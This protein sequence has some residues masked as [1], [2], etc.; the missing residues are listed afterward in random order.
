VEHQQAHETT[1]AVSFFEGCA[2]QQ[3]L[4]PLAVD[5][6]TVQLESGRFDALRGKS[7]LFGGI[8]AS[9][10]AIGTPVYQ[11]R[12]AGVHAFR[13]D[14]SDIPEG[15]PQL[16]D[17]YIAVSQ[18]GRSR[19][20]VQ[21]LLSVPDAYSL[22]ITN[23]ASNPLLSVSSAGLSVGNFPD[24]RVSSIGFTATLL[25]L[26][27]LADRIAGGPVDSRWSAVIAGLPD[28]LAQAEDTLRLFASDVA[29]IGQ[30][31]VVAESSQITSSEQAGLLFR[32]GPRVPSTSMTTRSYL[33]GPMDSA[34]RRTSHIVIGRKREAILAEQLSEQHVP[35]LFM[36]DQE[37]PAS[38]RL[39]HV[40]SGFT[41]SQRALVEI[42]LLQRLVSL[43]GEANGVD[44]DGT[45]F[46]RLDTKVDSVEDVRQPA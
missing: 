33:H 14:C 41:S 28:V 37:A 29:E 13:T 26:G 17:A 18:G 36:S 11:L 1:H 39:V 25:A 2:S 27:M 30:V 6:L 15:A 7:L 23:S 16:A 45:V 22:A 34:G 38:A 4:L 24:S 46:R 32:E 40:P 21:L 10:A 35:I 19:E 31:D 43:V 20:T 12:A 42:V 44:V 9:F 5:A 8:G 3:S